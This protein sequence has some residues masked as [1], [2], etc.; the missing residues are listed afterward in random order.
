MLVVLSTGVP[1][2]T[3]EEVD[4]G[5]FSIFDDVSHPYSTFKF[6]YTHLEFDRLSRLMEYN[7]LLC[8]DIIF[9]NIGTCIKRRRR[10]SIRRPCT[11][12]DIARL[13]LNS[14]AKAEKL[15]EYI[16]MVEK[17]SNMSADDENE[18]VTPEKITGQKKIGDTDDS[19]LKFRPTSSPVMFEKGNDSFEETVAKA[20]KLQRSTVSLRN[21][22]ERRRLMSSGMSEVKEVDEQ[23]EQTGSLC[24]SSPNASPKTG[25]TITRKAVLNRAQAV[26]EFM[27]P[28]HLGHQTPETNG[29]KDN[30]RK[31]V[32]TGLNG[33]QGGH[34]TPIPVTKETVGSQGPNFV[35]QKASSQV[36]RKP[37]SPNALAKNMGTG[38]VHMNANK[39]VLPDSIS[40]PL[41]DWIDAA[42]RVTDL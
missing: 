13:S 40:K 8:K 14:K 37:L 34:P 20:S 41:E 35:S 19:L 30:S 18:Q 24:A 1:R 32:Q 22:L 36:P 39:T 38:D 29:V 3:Q 9:D 5:N 15:F 4:F 16:A 12:K 10:F 26:N 25:R 23:E 2:T 21:N 42:D 6:T 28:T 17:V 7:T 31:H 27:R 11:K 33:H